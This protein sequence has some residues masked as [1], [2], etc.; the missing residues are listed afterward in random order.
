MWQPSQTILVLSLFKILR[1]LSH[2]CWKM[3]ES[4]ILP[5]LEE[6]QICLCR[7]ARDY[8]EFGKP[9]DITLV[10]EDPP[11]YTTEINNSTDQDPSSRVAC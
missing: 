9:V 8:Q 2:F 11:G 7:L 5:S 6:G 4:L 3:E 1:L 10:A